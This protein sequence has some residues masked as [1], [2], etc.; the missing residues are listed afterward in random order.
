MTDDDDDLTLETLIQS[1]PSKNTFTEG[2][3][4]S[5]SPFVLVALHI[6]I[7]LHKGIR[8]G[9]QSPCEKVFTQEER[10]GVEHELQ[11]PSGESISL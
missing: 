7:V 2:G 4:T 9:P 8:G 1:T 3:L 10:P 5:L 11:W 6:C